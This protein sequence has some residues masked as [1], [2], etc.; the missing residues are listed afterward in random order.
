[1]PILLIILQAAIGLG[2]LLY[3]FA[4]ILLVVVFPIIWL[5]TIT[6]AIR[7]SKKN[8]YPLDWRAY[9]YAVMMGFY[10][11]FLTILTIAVLVLLLLYFFVDLSIS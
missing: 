9:A 6:R 1:M 5:T 11:G 7:K 10:Y 4:I 8:G 2:M 3:G